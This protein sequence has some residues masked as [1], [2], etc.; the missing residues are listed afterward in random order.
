MSCLWLEYRVCVLTTSSIMSTCDEVK[1]GWWT[2]EPACTVM[3]S[4]KTL[5]IFMTDEL[6]MMSYVIRGMIS[7][8]AKRNLILICGC[9]ELILMKMKNRNWFILEFLAF[10]FQPSCI[11]IC[12][13]ATLHFV[14]HFALFHCCCVSRAYANECRHL[15]NAMS[16]TGLWKFRRKQ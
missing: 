6:W 9:S 8:V 14:I 5:F 15:S 10:C 13:L 2:D 11:A 4:I 1:V 7:S 12:D 16:C 3:R